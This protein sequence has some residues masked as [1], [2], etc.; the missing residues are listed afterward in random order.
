MLPWFFLFV[1]GWF[2]YRLWNAHP[3]W[4]EPLTGG[5]VP[6]LTWLGRHSLLVYLLHQPILWGAVQV[7][8]L[9][10]G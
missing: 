7:F 2:L 3:R 4:R 1:T 5:Q 10:K 6:V 9:L 8:L